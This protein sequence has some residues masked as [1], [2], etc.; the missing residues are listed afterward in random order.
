MGVGT[1]LVRA[2]E[3]AC[4]SWGYDNMYLKVHAGNVAAEKLYENLGYTVHAP[5]DR[6]NEVMLCCDL[7]E[8]A[9]MD[10]GGAGDANR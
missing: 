5:K 4:L 10:S 2:C 9:L 6:K 8:R 3:T 7:Q 1:E